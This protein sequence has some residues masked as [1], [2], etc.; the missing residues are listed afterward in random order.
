MKSLP[1]LYDKKIAEHAHEKVKLQLRK[2]LW[3]QKEK[4]PGLKKELEAKKLALKQK[5]KELKSL[6]LTYDNSLN[7]PAI[8]SCNDQLNLLNKF[9]KKGDEICKILGVKTLY[10]VVHVREPEVRFVR[11]NQPVEFKLHSAPFATYH[12]KI[13]KIRQT[14][15]KDP[16]NPRNVLYDA[17][18]H[19]ENTGPLKP[20]MLGKAKIIAD[21]VFLI[22]YLWIKASALLRLDLFY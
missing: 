18:I 7:Q 13:H 8:I 4:V 22:H 15:Q 6:Q 14:S 10:T 17:E 5:E 1:L 16:K 2:Q 3:E 19:I 20:G 9:Y 12:G 21:K 11:E